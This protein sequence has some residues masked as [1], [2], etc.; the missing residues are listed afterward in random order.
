MRQHDFYHCAFLEI[1]GTAY[2]DSVASVYR[3]DNGDQLSG[4]VAD[5]NGDPFR[6]VFLVDAKDE[7][8][9]MP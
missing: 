6:N 4:R 2:R 3:P 9:I 7:R 8:T 5:L 1:L